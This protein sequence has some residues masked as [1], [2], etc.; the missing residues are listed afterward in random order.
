MAYK[1][2]KLNKLFSILYFTNLCSADMYL[3]CDEYMDINSCIDNSFCQW[4]NV[5]TTIYNIKTSNFNTPGVCKPNTECLYNSTEC[6]SNNHIVKICNV[7]DCFVSVSL[8]FI[9]F[10]SICYISYF[11]KS[12]LDK[13]FDIP[14]NNGDGL[15]NRKEAK[16]FLLIIINMLL[17][18]PPIVLWLIN[19]YVFI[20]YSLSI[21]GLI[22]L[23]S[24][25]TITKKYTTY[26]KFY[27]QHTAYTRIN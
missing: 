22:I 5:N 14:N 26:S 2:Y 13:Y 27:K 19:K 4:C 23:L 20:Y 3:G 10:S 24:F 21:M 9:L 18:V 8:L 6:I 17:F 11:T 7:L 15:R 12:I 1:V 25:T 16:K